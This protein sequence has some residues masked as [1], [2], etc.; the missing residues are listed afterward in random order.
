L[1]TVDESPQYLAVR[2]WW[3]SPQNSLR[4][5]R[6]KNLISQLPGD[7]SGRDDVHRLVF[8]E[9]NG[10]SSM[11]QEGSLV[12]H[13]NCNVA[14]F[15]VDQLLKF[16]D[17]NEIPHL[18]PKDI[19]V[20]SPFL[21]QKTLL[22]ENISWQL[23][24]DAMMR[25]LKIRTLD[26]AQENQII[27]LDLVTGDRF[28]GANIGFLSQWSRIHDAITKAKSV[29]FI[30]LNWTRVWRQM[31]IF[32]CY[33]DTLPWAL[34]LV[35]ILAMGDLVKIPQNNLTVLLVNKGERLHVP[36]KDW[37]GHQRRSGY[38][39]PLITQGVFKTSDTKW[40]RAVE[41]IGPRA[42]NPSHLKIQELKDELA[43][44]RAKYLN[45]TTMTCRSRGRSRE[46]MTLV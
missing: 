34:F 24:D 41:K 8:D 18:S 44:R 12:N 14:T 43:S 39:E 31:E 36:Q 4:V 11:S 2:D 35:D 10:F 22:E 37:T 5:F 23:D 28:N 33:P 27:V 45:N 40:K 26:A 21:Q 20:V 13:G 16:T 7:E 1:V 19:T 15:L 46:R 25:D 29:I 3:L 30:L 42:L 6:E 17:S 38:V 9:I 32:A